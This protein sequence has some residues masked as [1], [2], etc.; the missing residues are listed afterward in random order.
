MVAHG[1]P[2]TDAQFKVLQWIN[3]GRPEGV[4]TGSAHR[5]SARAL[6]SRGLARVKGHGANW[7]AT[8]EP[9]GTYY[10]EHGGFPDQPSVR[11]RARSAPKRRHQ[12][13][14]EPAPPPIT[15]DDAAGPGTRS[16]PNV[17][18]LGVAAQ[19]IETLRQAG[20]SGLTVAPDDLPAIRRRL[21]HAERDNRIPAE[22]RVACEPAR[23][24]EQHAVVLRLQP[25]PRWHVAALR[26]SPSRCRLKNPTSCGASED[27][28]STRGLLRL[29]SSSHHDALKVGMKPRQV[30]DPPASSWVPAVGG[31]TISV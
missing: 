2:L 10:L 12:P 18:K 11:R 6:A 20:K 9:A 15:N 25:S 28:G 30:G 23:I 27:E 4:V 5:T 26:P 14:P 19:L 24:N 17:P 29:K 13:R 8:I 1:A 31:R 16:A 21:A 7:T 3:D 22:H